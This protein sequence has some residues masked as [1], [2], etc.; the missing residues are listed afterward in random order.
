MA[1]KKVQIKTKQKKAEVSFFDDFSS[2]DTD[3][4]ILSYCS[5]K[6]DEEPLQPRIDE[7]LELPDVDQCAENGDKEEEKNEEEDE[8]QDEEP[9]I[10]YEEGI[11]PQRKKIKTNSNTELKINKKPKWNWVPLKY[12]RYRQLLKMKK[13]N[14]NSDPDY[15]QLLENGD[16]IPSRAKNIDEDPNND[17]KPIHY[18]QLLLNH[19]FFD[20]VVLETNLARKRKQMEDEKTRRRF[21]S[22][23]RKKVVRRSHM[24]KWKDLTVDEFKTFLGLFYWMGLVRLPDMGD[25][26]STEAIFNNIKFKEH[27]SRDR[28]LQIL[29]HMKFH[30]SSLKVLTS[31]ENKLSVLMDA[32]LQNSKVFYTPS[33]TLSLDESMVSFKGRHKD[34]VFMPSKPIR[35]GFKAFVVC[36]ADTGFL[37]EWMMYNKDEGKRTKRIVNTVQDLL[38]FNIYQSK[39]V[40]MDRYYSSKEVFLTLQEKGIYACGTIHPSRVGVTEEMRGHIEQLKNEKAIYYTDDKLLLC[41]WR[42]HKG[43][44]VYILSSLLDTTMQDSER[45]S[46]EGKRTIPIKRPS[47]LEAYNENM[48]G[49]DYFDRHIRYYS[50]LHGSKK[51]YLKIAYYF[52][53]VAVLNSYVIYQKDCRKEK[54]LSRKQY[55]I[56]IIHFLLGIQKEK[57]VGGKSDCYLTLKSE[58]RNCIICSTPGE[59][60]KRTNFYCSTCFCYVCAIKC[61]DEHRK[62]LFI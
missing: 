1:K 25:H 40:Y 21:I 12:K 54:C 27:M 26:W 58:S 31:P 34:K 62:R 20:K 60:R 5:I 51:W 37:L 44:L 49:V 50:F 55:F 6:S 43:K 46:L 13:S 23:R 56:D 19:E 42:T 30:D 3:Q 59:N 9:E 14:C 4:E 52:L 38:G 28:F 57:E 17:K 11:E 61:Y 33:S 53:E 10:E 8:D 35:I 36:E 48:R 2:S 18:L 32:V 45:Y 39:V 7:D 24:V 47:I 22:I 29:R 15:S 41:I 16:S